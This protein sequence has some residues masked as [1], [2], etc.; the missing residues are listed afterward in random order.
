[1]YIPILKNRSV[2][3]SVFQKLS[4][5]HVFDKNVMPM[6]ELIQERTRS[7]MKK[8]FLE[9]LSDILI[10][11]PQM[12]IMVDF[13][14]TSKLRSTS[15]AV[16]NYITQVTRQPGYY[17]NELNKLG[18]FNDQ[19]IPVI[20]YMIEDISIPQIL[21]DSEKLRKTF[22]CIAYRIKA[23]EFENVFNEIVKVVRPCDYVILDIDAAPYTSPVFK[24]IY[25]SIADSKKNLHFT[26][27]VVNANRSEALFNNRMSDKEPIPEI[28]NGLRDFYSSA[29]MSRFDGFGDYASI[30]AALPTTGGTISPVG[31]YYSN[32]NNFFVAFK[33]RKPLL[34]EFPDYIVPSIIE[35]EYWAEYEDK[36]HNTCP[37]CKTILDIK[38]GNISGKNQALWKGISMLHYIYTLY[39][40]DA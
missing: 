23:T 29:Y 14:K 24:K 7:N 19:V 40:T 2:E 4:E 3:V 11:T 17:I 37:G 8:T 28:D 12:K 22:K 16:R 39:E 30:T 26:S 36:H 18:E 34:S 33:G 1:M 35:S 9:E 10:K 5:L 6:L 20:S 32:E 27:I 13:Y 15:D 38:S 21:D 31:I 25:K